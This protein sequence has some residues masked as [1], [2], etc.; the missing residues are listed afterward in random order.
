M[1]TS[2]TLCSSVPSVVDFFISCITICSEK[3]QD[4]VLG[5]AVDIIMNDDGSLF[6]G[7]DIGWWYMESIMRLSGA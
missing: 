1:E 6:V 5:R 3:K 7:G 2:I 4:D